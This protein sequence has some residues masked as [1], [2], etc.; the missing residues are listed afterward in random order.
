VRNETG[1]ERTWPLLIFGHQQFPE[2]IF[3]CQISERLTQTNAAFTI[4]LPHAWV[5]ST[6]LHRKQL[7]SN[8]PRMVN[9]EQH[10]GQNA[11]LQHPSLQRKTSRTICN[12]HESTPQEI[13]VEQ[14]VLDRL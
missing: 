7:E 10:L 12:N 13:S 2:I 6:H 5:W 1:F 11:T 4:T 8:R 9:H 14:T 3:C